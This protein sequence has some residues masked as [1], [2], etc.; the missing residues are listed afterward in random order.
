MARITLAL[1]VLMALGLGY[2]YY[3]LVASRRKGV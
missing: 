1:L 2:L 3:K